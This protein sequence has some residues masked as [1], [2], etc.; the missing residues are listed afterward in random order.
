MEKTKKVTGKKKA[1]VEETTNNDTEITTKNQTTEIIETTQVEKIK[2]PRKYKIGIIVSPNNYSD[3]KYYN[4]DFKAINEKYGD[5]V[6]LIF[7]GYDYKEDEQ[8]ILDGVNFEYTEQVS[9]IHFYK[10]L[11]SLELDLVFVP[12]EKN[13]YNI[14]TEN[15]NKYLECGLFNIPI[16]VEDMFPYNYVVVNER[17]GF[18]YKGKENFLNEFNRLLNNPDLIKAVSMETKKDIL[19]SYTYTDKNIDLIASIYS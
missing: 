10:Q 14:T 6:T 9:I 16:L 1:K 15:I 11:Q 8:K 13:L 19:R 2:L 4:Q 12:L 5:D 18:V 17:N 7:I 3:L